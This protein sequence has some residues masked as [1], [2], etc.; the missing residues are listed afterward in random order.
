MKH[1]LPLIIVWAVQ[2]VAAPAGAVAVL[3]FDHAR[4]LDPQTVE[5]A[6]TAAAG[7]GTWQIGASGRIGLLPDLDA[8]LRGGWVA[9]DDESGFE[10]EAGGRFRFLRAQDTGGVADLAGAAFG[11]VLKTGDVFLAGVDPQLLASHHFAVSGPRT[12]H[13]AA[14]VGLATTFIDVD[15]GAEDAQLGLLAA[16]SAGFDITAQIEIDIEV[17][18]RDGDER[19]GL[20]LT[21]RL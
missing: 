11:S 16:F 1:L 10:V 5:V 18:H 19:L 14:A 7:S 4:P 3:G 20:A 12:L 13:A 21:L 6:A 17:R 15:G 9:R 2:F 8:A